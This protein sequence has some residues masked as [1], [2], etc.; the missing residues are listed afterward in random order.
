MFRR[1]HTKSVVLTPIHSRRTN[2]KSKRLSGFIMAVVGGALVAAIAPANHAQE[3]DPLYTFTG[4]E[5]QL[6]GWVVAGAGDVNNDGYDDVILGTNP[7]GSGES[8]AQA[9]VHSGLDGSLLYTFDDGSARFAL[10][11]GGAGDVNN[12]GY[13]DLIVGDPV[14]GTGQ[15][16]VYSGLD[17]SLLRVFDGQAGGD[18]F[19][20]AVA[21]AGDVNND[22]YD[23][24]I[25]GAANNDAGGSL[26]GRA[27]VYSGLNGSLLHTFTGG[28]ASDSLG[29]SVDGAGDVNGDG[30]V[31][32]IVGAPTTG[33]GLGR[34]YVYSGATGWLLY[35]F[36][37]D[38]VGHYFAHANAAAGAGDVNNDGYDDLIVGAMGYDEWSG[39]AYVYSGETGLPLYTFTG[40]A[41]NDRVGRSVSG[42]GDVNNDGYDDFIVGAGVLARIYSGR[43]GATL[44]TVSVQDSGLRCVAGAGDVSADGCAD[45]ILG[46]PYYDGSG[47][48]ERGRA[49]VFRGRGS[50]IDGTKFNDVNANGVRDPGEPGLVG[51]EIYLLD[52]SGMEAGS[53]TTNAEGLYSFTDIGPGT[54]TVWETQQA[55]WAQ[56]F[57]ADEHHEVTLGPCDSAEGIDFGNVCA[58]TI[59][60]WKYN[61]LNGNGIWDLLEPGIEGWTIYLTDSDGNMRSTTTDVDGVCVFSDLVPGHYTLSEEERPGWIQTFPGGEGVHEVDTDP[62]TELLGAFG[63]VCAS[64][65]RGT[66][67]NDLNGNGIWDLPEPGIEGWTIY[68]T[69]PDG[70]MRSTTTDVDGVFVFSDLVPGHY[71]LSEEE[72]PGWIQTFPGGEGVHELDIVLCAVFLATF[73]NVQCSDCPSP[74]WD[75]TVGQMDNWVRAL[76][77]FDNYLYAGGDFTSAGGVGGT[78]HVARWDGSSWSE[79]AGGTN[80]LVRALAVFDG[81]LYVGGDFTEAGGVPG[82]QHLAQ[83][84]G[85]SW[86]GGVSHP[87]YALAVSPTALYAAIYDSSLGESYVW[88]RDQ[89]GWWSP[90]GPFPG[91][92]F[93]GRINDLAVQ[94]V[95]SFD[96]VYAGGNFTTIDGFSANYIAEWDGSAGSWGSLDAGLPGEVRALTFFDDGAGAALH[97]GHSDGTVRSFVSKW[98]ADTES[99]ST[100]G[101]AD[102]EL[103]GWIFELYALDDLCG[104]QTLY[105][106]GALCCSSP[107]LIARWS[108]DDSNPWLPLGNGLDGEV[109]FAMAKFDGA[110]VAGG[111]FWFAGDGPADHVAEWG[112]T[113]SSGSGFVWEEYDGG[114]F[115]PSPRR[116]HAMAFDS[117]RGVTV[118]FGGYNDDRLGDTWEWDGSSW[119]LRATD[120]PSPRSGAGMTYDS[121]RGVILLQGGHDGT[122]YQSDTWEWDGVEWSHRSDDGPAHNAFGM[123]F[124]S[125]RGV[126]VMFGGTTATGRGCSTFEWDGNSWTQVDSCGG[127]TYT[128]HGPLVYDSTRGVTVLFGGF[129]PGGVANGQTW[130]W[131]GSFWSL[132]SGSGPSARGGH[133][134]AY[135]PTGEVTVL[136]GGGAP[137]SPGTYLDDTW[138]WDGTEWRMSDATGPSARRHH[139]MAYDSLRD[140]VVLFG[141]YGGT[142]QNLA[143]IWYYGAVP[144][145]FLGDLNC[146]GAVD[147]FDIDPFVLAV[148]DSAGYAAVYPDCDIMLADCNGD[149]VVDFF[150]IDGFVAIITGG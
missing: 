44:G 9:Y 119:A 55:G 133:R 65:I 48:G 79:L 129:N 27:Y 118:L 68:L 105:V 147:F 124:D 84:N 87:V 75:G 106:G 138:E 12:D 41:E 13:D 16:Y 49:V 63:N 52:S 80:G 97:A 24:M 38:G 6:L 99:W 50:R 8:P 102:G 141:G 51:W 40:G 125:A 120:G 89:S 69:D 150:D 10:A 114:E 126:A 62:C 137:Q 88:R 148:T 96:M 139:G 146:D 121:A 107:S 23:D 77:V 15:A 86:L 103:D 72:R 26:A 136:F 112:C 82:T 53:T 57:P 2:A 100:L 128:S 22:G 110:L 34:A 33:A 113:E 54:Y 94:S 58:S 98:D 149:G 108:G 67:Y 25:I 30:F 140:G 7:W 127:P 45:V 144:V 131:D 3:C 20:W 32:L 111:I 85:S 122:S 18:I 117:G 61:D 76:T 104:R 134:M 135:H 91:A 21:G 71:T 37:A 14:P 43:D 17:G 115:R 35:T 19:G 42:A 143:D 81:E 116:T 78:N 109:V 95:G 101:G 29:T 28:S 1:M 64:A 74:E 66:K 130:E 73:G 46:S 132:R 39:R 93:N 92:A 31:D 47:D 70:N 145:P 56:T 60:V 5:H 142:E 83:W 59:R 11:V 36:T 4:G 123:T 90:L